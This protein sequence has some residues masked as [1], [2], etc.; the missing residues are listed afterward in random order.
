MSKRYLFVVSR[1]PAVGALA[2]EA[3]DLLLVAGAFDLAPAVLFIDGGVQHLSAR[4]T[5]GDSDQTRPVEALTA[6]GIERIYVD[7]E[8]LR[9]R[10][11]ARDALLLAPTLVEA[12]EIRRLI[13]ESDVVV[14]A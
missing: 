4:P 8:S 5:H 13:A 7:A 3:I 2:R 6:Y 12:D 10:Q 1:T 14:T 9:R 11:L